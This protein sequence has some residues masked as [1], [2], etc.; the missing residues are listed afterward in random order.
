MNE[1]KVTT[2]LCAEDRKRIDTLTEAMGYLAGQIHL[3]LNG[4]TYEG[5][6][7]DPIADLPEEVTLTEVPWEEHPVE[8]PFPEAPAEPNYTKDDI[9][10]LVV[11]LSAN[12]KKAE[13]RDIILAHGTSITDLPEESINT[14]FKALEALR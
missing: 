8:S 12:G 5:K 4:P 2:E 9:R 6:Q 13:A 11:T 10:K 7:P 3:L 14:V 1:I